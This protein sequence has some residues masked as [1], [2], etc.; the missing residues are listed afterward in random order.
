MWFHRYDFEKQTKSLH[1]VQM[2]GVQDRINIDH[3]SD[4]PPDQ[5]T[6]V[7]PTEVLKTILRSPQDNEIMASYFSMLIAR[8][9]VTHAIL[10]IDIC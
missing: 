9:L 4:D 6:P 1:Y 3:L 2:Y 7:P 8:V 10:Q 5:K